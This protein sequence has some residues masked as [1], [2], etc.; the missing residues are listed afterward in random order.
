MR[1]VAVTA[2]QRPGAGSPR[3][4]LPVA[5]LQSLEDAGLTP[6]LLPTTLEP[7]SAAGALDAVSGLVLSGGEDVDPSRYG[8]APHPRLG[9]IDAHRDAVEIELVRAAR[10]RGIPVLAICRGLQVVNVALGGT[11]Y[12]DLASERPGPIDHTDD[13]GRHPVCLDAGS[14]MA[15]TLGAG[16]IT[17]NSRHHQAVRDPAPALRVVARAPDGVVEG[18]ERADPEGGP[19]LLGVQWHPEDLPDAG[20]FRGF[21][22]AVEAAR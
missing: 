4:A 13:A 21:A 14:L 3:I 17:A 18:V 2:P 5:Y 8:A 10:T 12:Q 16:E 20:L 1:L 11:L 22:R 7:R 9:P 19:W 6:L 15:R